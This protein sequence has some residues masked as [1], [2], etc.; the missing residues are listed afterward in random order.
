MDLPR[1][2]KQDWRHARIA[3]LKHSGGPPWEQC[4]PYR[5]SRKQLD[6]RPCSPQVRRRLRSKGFERELPCP[7]NGVHGSSQEFV[8]RSSCSPQSRG[9]PS[10]R[11]RPARFFPCVERYRAAAL[12]SRY[13][14]VA[15][16]LF[17][18]SSGGQRMKRICVTLWAVGCPMGR[19][20]S[21]ERVWPCVTQPR[22]QGQ[23]CR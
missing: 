22:R 5:R 16:L 2:H 19:L 20:L 8:P 21:P 12:R 11:S 14:C 23:K 1:Q 3:R 13:C 10:D 18:H 15:S 4:N 9:A 6:H 17:F 7:S